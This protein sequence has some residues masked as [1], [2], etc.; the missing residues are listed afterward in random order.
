[1]KQCHGTRY[2]S[3]RQLFGTAWHAFLSS[4]T[5]DFEIAEA[6]FPVNLEEGSLTVCGPQGGLAEEA[7]A[8]H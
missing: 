4:F 1:M 5:L 8:R 6:M 2:L 7:A 3:L